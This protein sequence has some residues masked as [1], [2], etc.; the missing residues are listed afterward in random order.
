MEIGQK[1]VRSSLT[2]VQPRVALRYRLSLT[3][4]D[5]PTSKVRNWRHL[6]PLAG[7]SLPTMAYTAIATQ[8]ADFVPHFWR[9]T[10]GDVVRRLSGSIRRHRGVQP[11]IAALM[12]RIRLVP[13]WLWQPTLFIFA[14][15][16]YT[17]W[18]AANLGRQRSWQRLRPWPVSEEDLNRAAIP[19]IVAGVRLKS[20]AEMSAA[21]VDPSI[22]Q[23]ILM[24]TTDHLAE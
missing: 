2:V 23:A 15:T 6:S 14:C 21:G 20:F 16:I 18:P 17:C 22:C 10:T 7:G 4:S 24:I 8:R 5:L 19:Y 13:N 1:R 9:K 3:V 12:M 11:A